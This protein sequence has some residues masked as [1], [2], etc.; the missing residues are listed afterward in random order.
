MRVK[1]IHRCTPCAVVAGLLQLGHQLVNDVVSHRLLVRRDVVLGLA[2]EVD[3]AHIQRVAPQIAGHRVQNAFNRN[4]ALRPT[5]TTKSRVALGIG[6]AHIAM[7]A[8][9]GQ[10]VGIVKVAQRPRH[11][12]C[13]QVGRMPC[14]RDH[15]NLS[16]QHTAFIVIAHFVFVPEAV[17]ATGN[18]EVVIAIQPQLHRPVQAHSSHR[19]HAGKQRRLRFFAAKATAHAAAL[20]MHAVRSHA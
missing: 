18:H 14:A 19:R 20:H 11:H 8:D 2:V 7:G 5:K 6:L 15:G 9:I 17:T 16:P 1:G 12:R 10:P 4:R 3:A 13:R